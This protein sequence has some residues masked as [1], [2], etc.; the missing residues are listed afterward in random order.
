MGNLEP[1]NV[2]KSQ[3]GCQEAVGKPGKSG[4]EPVCCS[5]TVLEIISLHTM[6]GGESRER[7]CL[8]SGMGVQWA[9]PAPEPLLPPTLRAGSLQ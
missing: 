1:G 7:G 8:C 5:L 6:L 2:C 4:R 3:A 9:F